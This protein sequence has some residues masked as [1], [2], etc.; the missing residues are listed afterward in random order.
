ML[1]SLNRGDA[2]SR[3]TEIYI[4][5][6]LLVFPLF[7]GLH[8]YA[9]ITAAKF[10]MFSALTAAWLALLAVFTVKYRARPARPNGA[11]LAS[12]MLLCLSCLSAAL[13]QYGSACIFGAGRYD[14]LVSLAM[15]LAVFWGVSRFGTFL[16]CH[17]AAFGTSTV[18]CC[19]I[20]L[21]QLL[22][23]NPLRLFPGELCYYDAHIKYTSE[24]LGTVGNVNLLS[25]ILVLAIALFA[26]L[27]VTAERRA[28]AVSLIPLG[29][30]VFT[31]A[32]SGVA[33]GMAALAF[34]A[35]VG[36]PLLIVSPQRLR[37]VL[38]A[39]CVCCVCAG[40]ALCLAPEYTD[41]VLTMHFRAGAAAR[42][43]FAAAAAAAALILPARALERK[44]PG[45]HL[46]RAVLALET[47]AVIAALAL[48][49][50]LP[51]DSGTLHELSEVLHGRI[52]D[53]FG[54]SR[55][56]I[57]RRV[58]ELAR[59]HP[60]LGAGPGTI[61]LRLDIEFS[62]FVP[63]TGQTLTSFADNAHNVYLQ[64]LAD[65]GTLGLVCLLWLLCAAFRQFFRTPVT[66]LRQGAML[67]AAVGCAAGFFG[68]GLCL[69]APLFWLFI[70]LMISSP[71]G[72]NDDQ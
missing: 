47:A 12:L 34:G 5:L 48:L 7:T 24:F 59:S 4:F 26:S 28:A 36:A 50:F 58:L 67:A 17:A 23:F 31:L 49:W 10:R 51:A 66:A 40:C 14:G 43:L 71:G 60:L 22:G 39:L 35:L 21:L 25:D 55:I 30:A 72:S 1:T 42:L 20:A 44:R 62:R 54:S 15:Y 19:G 18:L 8:G 11:Q 27:A 45:L 41:S 53:S 69:S 57:W 13:S 65:T 29:A 37:R 61:S 70:G 2:R 64:C 3:C 33:G 9:S 63:E 46:R 38:I 32:A 52:D 56:R 16:P 6:M 68:L